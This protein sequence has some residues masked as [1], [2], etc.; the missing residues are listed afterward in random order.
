MRKAG[1]TSENQRAYF[2]RFLLGRGIQQFFDTLP[3]PLEFSA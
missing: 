2:A 1:T 3:V